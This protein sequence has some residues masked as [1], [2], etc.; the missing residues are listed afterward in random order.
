MRV[1]ITSL[2]T[3]HG[4]NPIVQRLFDPI[5]HEYQ[6]AT[7]ADCEAIFLSV[8]AP[9]CEFFLDQPLLDRIVNRGVPVVIFDHTET[10][11]SSVI[12]GIGSMHD[13][14]E[15]IQL[16]RAVPALKLKAYF[17]RELLTGFQ[18]PLSCPLYPLDWTIPNWPDPPIDTREQ[19]EARPIDLL[20]SW[21]YSSES[22]PR[23]YGELMR[24][25]GKFAAHFALTDEDVDRSLE[26]KRQRI[27]ALLFAPYYR[28]IHIDRI[29]RWQQQC[30]LSISLRGCGLKCFRCAEASYNS[31]LVQQTPWVVQWS[32]S[33]VGGC[34]REPNCLGLP[35]TPEGEIDGDASMD[36]LYAWLRVNQGSLYDIYLRCIE[37][38]KNYRMDNYSNGYLLPRL[39]KALG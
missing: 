28:R 22:R 7:I 31:L 19:Y 21:G 26:D 37:N 34:E 33:W 2:N 38:G 23:L 20:M 12:L 5:A 27:F 11:E 18:S 14:N 32:F 25:A 39:R 4:V 10:K 1:L 24:K 17:K 6:P 3:R 13:S 36:M 29:L 16:Q 8:I 30:K 15:Y 35:N 9:P